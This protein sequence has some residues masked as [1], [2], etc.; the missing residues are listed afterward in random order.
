M[1]SEY[2]TKERLRDEWWAGW[3]IGWCA[4]A[5]LTGVLITIAQVIAS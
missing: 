1:S 4:G 3:W 2:P 5:A